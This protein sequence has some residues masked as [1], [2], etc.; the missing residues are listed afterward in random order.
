[1]EDDSEIT[2][3]LDRIEAILEGMRKEQ[4]DFYE[5]LLKL[6]S[7]QQ[8]TAVGV[9]SGLKEANEYLSKIA[10]DARNLIERFSIPTEGDDD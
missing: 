1:M 7:E 5:G 3:A 10:H 6:L 4:R 9:Q 2:G 8:Q